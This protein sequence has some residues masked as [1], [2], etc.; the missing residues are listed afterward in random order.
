MG[1][2]LYGDSEKRVEF[3]KADSLNLRFPILDEAKTITSHQMFC[4]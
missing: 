1:K 2:N 4:M 3:W